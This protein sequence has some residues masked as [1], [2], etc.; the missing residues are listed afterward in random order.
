[1]IP[2]SIMFSKPEVL[3]SADIRHDVG[4]YLGGLVGK[5]NIDSIWDPTSMKLSII[6]NLYKFSKGAMLRDVLSTTC[7]SH[8]ESLAR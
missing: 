8:Y 7:I 5:E 1:M 2:S 3:I 6:G 4:Q